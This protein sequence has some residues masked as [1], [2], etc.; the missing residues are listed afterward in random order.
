MKQYT[1]KAIAQRPVA[2]PDPLIILDRGF[3]VFQVVT[4]DINDVVALLKN[5][6]TEVT[7]INELQQEPDALQ[8]LLVGDETLNGLLGT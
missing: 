6:G 8:D 5:E 2:I 1:L 4:G 7:E 3:N